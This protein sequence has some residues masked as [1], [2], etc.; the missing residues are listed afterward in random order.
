MGY[1]FNVFISYKRSKLYDEWVRDSFY[2]LLEECLA[3]SLAAFNMDE[4][5]FIDRDKLR[6]GEDWKKKIKNALATSRCLVCLLSPRYFHSFCCR[7][8]YSV[9]YN[10]QK[11]LGYQTEK[12]PECLI[13]PF[14]INDG[15]HFSPTVKDIQYYDC[16][17]FARSSKAFKE[18]VRHLEFEDKMMEWAENISKVVKNAP[19]WNP[20]WLKSEWLDVPVDIILPPVNIKID[21]SFIG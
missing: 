21:P 9:I 17:K 14:K 10:R 16:R 13:V 15:D 5:I 18:S 19:P 1:K 11:K 7:Y 3:E 20:E 8:E 2:P 6:G 12:K 4:G